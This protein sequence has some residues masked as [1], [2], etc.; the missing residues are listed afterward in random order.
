M[1]PRAMRLSPQQVDPLSWVT[2]PWITL[3]FTIGTFVLGMTTTLLTWSISARP[4]LDLIALGVILVACGLAY[5]LTRPLQ[6]PLSPLRAAMPLS[7]ALIGVVVSALAS[8]TS[9]VPVQLWW[10]PLG[11][12]FVLALLAPFSSARAL[13]GYGAVLTIV[14]AIAAAIAF[15]GRSE[16]WSDF[17]VVLIAL[18]SPLQAT[19][20]CSVFAFRVVYKTRRLLGGVGDPIPPSDAAHE[21]AAEL[22]HVTTIARLGARVAPFLQGIADAGE[23]TES[24]RALAGQLARRLRSELVTQANRTWLDTIAEDRRLYVVD[25]E[26]RADQMNS[27][28]RA[29][30]R[31]VIMSVIDDPAIDEG[32][33][34]I[35][36]RGRDDGSTAVA[37]SLNLDLPE[38]KRT[39]LLAP[40]FVALGSAVDEISWDPVLELLRFR[41]PP[42][43]DR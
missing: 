34:L 13:L 21:R 16:T 38:G 40:Y 29:G 10:A 6:P 3:A 12:S 42:E 28:Q 15:V 4:Y 9:A 20:L 1:I 27:A 36:L 37:L 23:V 41:V 5:L 30:L 35:E 22:A 25:P 2:R 19:V 11:A 33:L 14:V 8:T 39:M 18:G 17:S 7:A 32:S 26:R 43:T 31:G 24:D